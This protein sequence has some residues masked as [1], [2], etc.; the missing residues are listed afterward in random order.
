MTA[1]HIREAVE[2]DVPAIV[3]M[4]A[5]DHLGRDR[6]TPGDPA[7]AEAFRAMAAQ[8][9]NHLFVGLLD[10]Q[11][12]ACAQLIFQPGLSRTG[13]MRATIEGVRV[14]SAFRRRGHGERIIRHCVMAARAGGAGLVQLTSDR[15]R[16]DAHRFYERL[17]FKVTS[18]G[19]KLMLG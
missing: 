3:L 19:M 11:I 4:L 2:G 10:T 17:G 15:S 13:T 8:G 16:T 9:G 5:D 18:V 7:Y 6:E 14:A 1:L 12:V